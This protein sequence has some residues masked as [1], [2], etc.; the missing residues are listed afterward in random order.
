MLDRTLNNKK[1]GV[2]EF[3]DFTKPSHPNFNKEYQDLVAKDPKIFMRYKGIFSELYDS[4]WRNGNIYVP[5]R[6]DEKPKKKEAKKTE[7]DY[8]DF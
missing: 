5:F 2:A 1:K 6:N 7:N 4:A 3:S 8:Y